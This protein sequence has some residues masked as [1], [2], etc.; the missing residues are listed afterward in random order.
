MCTFFFIAVLCTYGDSSFF[1]VLPIVQSV[2]GE[3]HFLLILLE[4]DHIWFSVYKSQSL[5]FYDSTDIEN[6]LNLYI[7]SVDI[8]NP[9][10]V[11][12]PQFTASDPC[13]NSSA[14]APSSALALYSALALSSAV[15]FSSALRTSSSSSSQTLS[16]LV[17]SSS[18]LEI[19]VL[20]KNV[21][22]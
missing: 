2:E 3:L 8:S 14:L 5:R 6:D 19:N 11:C 15:E 1:R 12:E 7:M 4:S 13:G 22:F 10:H 21:D 16:A 20:A 17:A 9:P 18:L